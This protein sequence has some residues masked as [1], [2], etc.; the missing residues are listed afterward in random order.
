MGKVPNV[1]PFAP[2]TLATLPIID[3][4]AFATA[5]AG[6]R[7]KN[8]TDLLLAV[9]DEGTSVA[10]VLTQ[11]KTASAPVL[12]CRKHLKKGEARA[13]VVNSGNANAFT[14]KKGSD[15][16]DV[17]VAHAVEAVGCK[18]H[19]V[20]VASTGVIGEPLDAEKFAHLLSGLAKEVEPNAFEKAARAIMTTDTYPKLATRTA[21][22]G[23]V[24]VTI[25]GFCKGA[26]MIAP[27]MATMLCFI[28]TDAAISSD[29]LQELLAEHAE[30]TFNCMTVDGD[31]S[32]SDT[33]LMFATGKAE[34]RGQKPITKAKS[35]KLQAFSEAL[36]DLMRDLAIQVAKDGEGLTKFVTFEVGGAKSWAA[37]RAIALSCANSPILK[38]AIAGE[39][40]NW[41]RVVMAVGKS[42]EA[43]DRD[44]LSIWFGPYCVARDGERAEDYDEKTVAAYMKNSE[45]LIRVDVGVGKSGARVWTCDLTHE[46]V[47]IN[48]DYRS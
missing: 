35:K 1:S 45:I 31:T 38:T 12:A 9:L 42:G 3:G 30:T 41:G 43:A 27:D 26:G 46:Y 4:V 44:R 17:T 7:Y 25:N 29:A 28:F 5:E 10:G 8:R 20:F 2:K 40:P 36:Y 11:S 39:D 6:I 14:G 37:A 15:A 33:C 47:S 23:D 19:E 21:L 48:A 32:T 22:I 16:V 34:A 24:A 13:L 18:P